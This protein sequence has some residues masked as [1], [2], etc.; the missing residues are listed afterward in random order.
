MNSQ[1]ASTIL[2]EEDLLN[3]VLCNL[4]RTVRE[5]T[6]ATTESACP[7]IRQMFTDLTN[8]TLRLQGDLFHL[9][10]QQNQYTPASKASRQEVDKQLQQSRKT[11]QQSHQFVQQRLGGV[12]QTQPLPQN[13]PN[14][15]NSNYM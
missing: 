6:T 12:G 9:M 14:S 1:S 7:T 8:D 2:P 3:T 10:Q 13:Q 11:Q 15:Q 4:K 5:Y